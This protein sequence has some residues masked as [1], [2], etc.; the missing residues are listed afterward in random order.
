MKRLITNW[1]FAMMFAFVGVLSANAQDFKVS[2][3]R[4]EQL[5]DMN[6]AR[7]AHR[8]FPSG[9]NFVVVGGH[10]KGFYRE[11]S[12]EIYKNGEWQYVT[13][14]PTSPHDNA[15]SVTLKDGRTLVF[16]G[17]GG[18]LGTGG[19]IMDI[20]IYDPATESF[21]S[22][23]DMLRGRAMCNG[24]EIGDDVFIIGDYWDNSKIIDIIWSDGSE[25]V[26]GSSLTYGDM[27]PYLLPKSNNAAFLVIGNTGRSDIDMVASTGEITQIT[28]NVFDEWKPLWPGEGADTP[29][30]SIGD[31]R[32]LLLCQKISDSDE[33]GVVLV[34]ADAE[35]AK[36]L[37]TL[38]SQV[39]NDRVS[40]NGYMITNP[41]KDEAYV[42]KSIK[43]SEANYTYFIATVDYNNSVVKE[44]ATAG[45][46]PVCV[47]Y[48]GLAILSDGRILI[49]GGSE[50]GGSNYDAHNKVFA[51]IP[52]GGPT[53][54][55][56]LK[57]KKT[58]GLMYYD[59]Q[60][61]R[62]VNPNKGVYIQNGRKVVIQ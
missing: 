8:I 52:N 9:D 5:A 36:L 30:F 7:M 39:L 25:T 10:T 26:L 49:A 62:V 48:S 55:V 57:N 11:Q 58:E 17:I 53:G 15:G 33:Y 34:D 28:M 6:T 38:P 41:A 24:V 42:I 35:T 45:E 13:P 4:W 60:G 21:S 20:D 59:L 51:F 1:M 23:G 61:H 19:G 43:A 12:A 54:I 37:V 40:W 16:G 31:G 22:G 46:L 56:E 44:I 29:D 18:N 50:T 14:G 3:L 47:A 27:Y 2:E 32:Y